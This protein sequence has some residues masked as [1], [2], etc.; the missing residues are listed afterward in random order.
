MQSKCVKNNNV[1][2]GFK[3]VLENEKKSVKNNRVLKILASHEEKS[4]KV[5]F[6]AIFSEK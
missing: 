6:K 1:K 3:I 5:F 2:N 4:K